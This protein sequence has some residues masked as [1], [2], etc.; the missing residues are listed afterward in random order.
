VQH[1]GEPDARPEVLGVGGDGDQGLGSGLEQQIIDDRLVLIGDVGDRGRQGEDDMEIR[2]GQ[3][4][5]LAVGQPLPG[6]GG[7]ALWAVRRHNLQLAEAHVAGM[8]R[9]PRRP[10]AAE[11]VR[12]LDR[13]P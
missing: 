12:H 1:G 4:F 10:A 8:G 11:D 9:S 6:S 2:H 3:E 7:L 5:G 13:W